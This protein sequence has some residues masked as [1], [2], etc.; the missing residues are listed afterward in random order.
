VNFSLLFTFLCSL[1]DC[2]PFPSRIYD[3][4]NILESIEIVRRK[5]KNTYIWYGKEHLGYVL[6]RLQQQAFTM[7]PEDAKTNGLLSE[8]S[9]ILNS[10]NKTKTESNKDKSLGRLSQKFIQMFLVGNNVLSL[11][12][13]S[14]KILGCPSNSRNEEKG[15]KTKVRRLY[16]IANVMVSIGI[17]QKVILSRFKKPSFKWDFIPPPKLPEYLN[18]EVPRPSDLKSAPNK[19]MPVKLLPKKKNSLTPVKLLSSST[20][21]VAL[22]EVQSFQP[23]ANISPITKCKIQCDANKV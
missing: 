10:D 20:T 13:A 2:L 1:H 12:E 23:G 8:G 11:A 22:K 7:W 15:M 21:S 17:I 6:A 16:D 19:K 5:C 3:I 9:I 14:E 18:T 4:I